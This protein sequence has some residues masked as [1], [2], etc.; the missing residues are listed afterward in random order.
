[1]SNLAFRMAHGKSYQLNQRKKK[2]MRPKMELLHPD[3]S[4]VTCWQRE[5]LATAHGLDIF[6]M[7][8]PIIVKNFSMGDVMEMKTIS[9]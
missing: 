7:E 5:V 6:T 4:F 3:Q 8:K 9:M 2:K 1:M